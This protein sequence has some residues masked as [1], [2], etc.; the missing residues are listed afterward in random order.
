MAG[1]AAR[2]RTFAARRQ[3]RPR[4]ITLH[5]VRSAPDTQTRHGLTVTTPARTLLDLAETLGP[6]DLRRAIR[7]AEYD[8]LVNHDQLTH[9][10]TSHPGR[11]GHKRLKEAIDGGTAPTQ[12]DFEDRFLNWS[13]D[14]GLPR[15]EINARIEGARVDFLWRRQRLI[16]ET[17]GWDAHSGRIAFEDDRERD[18]RLLAAGYIV[19]RVT[20]RQLTE[21]PT[22]LVARLAAL[23]AARDPVG[24]RRQA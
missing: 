3:R 12:N 17:D 24:H 22:R 15:P 19:M 1:V 7:Q 11:R 23:L 8:H 21:Q 2:S 14:A 10:L 6:D 18:Q 9:L 4:G 13:T 16:V 20:W 5:R